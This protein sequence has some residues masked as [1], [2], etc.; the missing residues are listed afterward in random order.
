[1][2]TTLS[3]AVYRQHRQ[4]R[5]CSSSVQEQTLLSVLLY[6]ING[7]VDAKTG[8]AG[9]P[10]STDLLLRSTST[11]TRLWTRYDDMMEWLA[12][13]YVRTL[14][15]IQYMHDKYYYEAAEL[16]LMDTDCTAVRLQRVSQDFLTLLTRFPLSSMQRLRLVRDEDGTCHATYEH[17]GRLPPL[18]KRRRPCGRDC[19]VWL[20][21]T[22]MGKIE[23]V[24]HT[25]RRSEPTTSILT[26]TSNVVYGKAT[27][28]TAGRQKSRRAAYHREQTRAT[29]Q[30]KSGLLSF[31]QLTSQNL[32]YEWALDG[33]SNT[34]TINPGRTRTRGW[35][36]V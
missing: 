12:E 22:F 1:M 15:V 4:V 3:A 26:I 34:Q 2:T 28:C 24:H 29:A 23:E 18:R 6:A 20:L 27:A 32:P 30:R 5:K 7:G 11:M 14:N 17:R 16:A 10:G 8:D 21:G 35:Q 13:V 25:Y 31:A 36:S 33:I 19:G 9:R